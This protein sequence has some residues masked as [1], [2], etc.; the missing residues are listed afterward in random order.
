MNVVM[1]KKGDGRQSVK[2]QKLFRVKRRIKALSLQTDSVDVVRG[3]IALGV[4]FLGVKKKKNYVEKIR[5]KLEFNNSGL[6]RRCN[7]L[8]YHEVIKNYHTG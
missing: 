5:R 1:I 6:G 4:K 2:K 7:N 8:N 3:E